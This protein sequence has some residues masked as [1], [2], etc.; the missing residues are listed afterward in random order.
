MAE[1]MSARIGYPSE[2]QQYF[3][4]MK[5]KRQPSDENTLRNDQINRNGESK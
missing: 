2:L 3:E 4:N 5:Q 1:K